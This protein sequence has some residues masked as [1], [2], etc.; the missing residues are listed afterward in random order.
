MPPYGTNATEE[1]SPGSP[2]T[3]VPDVERIAILRGNALGDLV[4]ALPALDALRRTYPQAEITLFGRAHH[5]ALLGDGRPSPV[6]RVVVLP[7]GAIGDETEPEAGLDRRA[8][9]ASFAADAYDLAIQLHGGGRNSNGFVRA[10]GARVTVGSRTPDAPALDRWVPYEPYQWEVARYLEVVAL[11]GARAHQLEPHLDVTAADRYA[12]VHALPDLGD[13][14]YVVLH[15]GASDPRRRWSVKRFARVARAAQGRGRRPVITGTPEERALTSALAADVGDSVCPAL[16]ADRLSL[17][18]LLGLLAGAD[19]VVSNDTGPLH[20]AMAAGTR[21][22]GLFW[23]GNLINA[24]P[25]TR[26]RHRPHVSWRLSC[27]V[28]GVSATAPR[29]AHDDSWVDDIETDAVVASVERLLEDVAWTP[30]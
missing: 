10:L 9:L 28:C 19:V 24:G 1:A 14:P 30:R 5:Q 25:L 7:H 21:T 27:P 17:S 20:L 6:D 29:C 16:I 13:A 3:I 12:A 26:A 11:V 15:P 23:I 4:M 8:L 18:A 2:V 22:V